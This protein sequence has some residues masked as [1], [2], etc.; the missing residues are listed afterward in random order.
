MEG[1]IFAPT[2]SLDLSFSLRSKV[3]EYFEARTPFLELHLPVHDDGGGDDDEMWS[4]N[5]SI[6]SQ[7]CEHGD[8]LNSLTKPHF[9]C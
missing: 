4:P 3:C 9:I 6:T 8:G 7:G 5:S 2:V 1:V